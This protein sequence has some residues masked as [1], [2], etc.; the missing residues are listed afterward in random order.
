MGPYVCHC[1]HIEARGKVEGVIF[2]PFY[3]VSPE[4]IRFGVRNLYSLSYL[5]SPQ[6]EGERARASYQM[7]AVLLVCILGTVCVQ[8]S[9]G[10]RS[11]CGG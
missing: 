8:R 6:R 11:V 10:S 5:T 2:F 7:Y 4:D 1:T 9:P 3:H